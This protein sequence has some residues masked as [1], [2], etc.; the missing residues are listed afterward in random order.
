MV[1][2][3]PWTLETVRKFINTKNIEEQT[4][5]L[6]TPDNLAGWLDSHRLTKERPKVDEESLKGFLTIRE[7]LRSL[8][9][10]NNRTK[11]D[12]GSLREFRELVNGCMLR[13][14]I[15][16]DGELLVEPEGNEL[17]RL[18]GS[19]LLELHRSMVVGTWSRLKACQ[20]EDCQE[21]FYDES[22]NHSRKWCDMAEGNKMKARRHLSRKRSAEISSISRSGRKSGLKGRPMAV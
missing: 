13:V 4:D 3:Q 20:N 2:A 21:A 1:D 11:F 12:A 5:T 17:E 14:N 8:A 6:T 7:G 9:L 15:S 10:L 18:E 19:L 16:D 22:R